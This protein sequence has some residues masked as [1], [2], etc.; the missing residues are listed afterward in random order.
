MLHVSSYLF[1]AE[2]PSSKRSDNHVHLLHHDDEVTFT[3]EEA[4]EV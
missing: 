2:E 4:E 1:V 3:P